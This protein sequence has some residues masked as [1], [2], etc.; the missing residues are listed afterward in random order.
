MEAVAARAGDSVDDATGGFAEFGCVVGTDDL[1]FLYCV[2]R[3]VVSTGAA[4]VLTVVAI[5]GID[6]VGGEVI[7][8]G[9]AAEGEKS[10]GTIICDAR[11]ES[12]EGVDAATV[13]GKFEELLAAKP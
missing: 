9:V 13:D 5:G 3:D 6:A 7:A 4:G 8:A 1:E 12:N 10:E 2:L 11:R